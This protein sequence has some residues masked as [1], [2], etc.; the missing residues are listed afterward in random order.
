MKSLT[1]S[2]CATW[3]T[4]KPRRSRSARRS[5]PGFCAPSAW[6]SAMAVCLGELLRLRRGGEQ[7]HQFLRIVRRTLLIAQR[8][9]GLHPQIEHF[10]PRRQAGAVIALQEGPRLQVFLM[11][12]VELRQLEQ[13]LR[14]RRVRSE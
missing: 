5:A 8:T 2:S 12:E 9:L 13:R 4:D 14:L 3:C 6:V 7:F 1:C 10:R 11:V